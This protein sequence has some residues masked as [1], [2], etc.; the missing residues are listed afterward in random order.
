MVNEVKLMIKL[1]Q[2]QVSKT[3]PKNNLETNEK[4]ILRERIISPEVIDKIIDDL[5]LKKGKY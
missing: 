5:R 2:S 4:E 3:L 1:H